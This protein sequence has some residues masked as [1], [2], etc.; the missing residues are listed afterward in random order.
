[1]VYS[2]TNNM[3]VNNA[4]T[5]KNRGQNAKNQ[6]NVQCDPNH[7]QQQHVKIEEQNSYGKAVAII[8]SAVIP[9]TTPFPLPFLPRELL[10]SNGRISFNTN[11]SIEQL[12]STARLE[13]IYM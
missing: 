12:Q 6:K 10:R 8:N 11:Y 5:K 2:Q 1:M 9:A 13:M 7:K 3:S 4:N